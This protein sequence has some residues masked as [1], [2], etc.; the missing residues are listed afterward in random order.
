MWTYRSTTKVEFALNVPFKTNCMIV[1]K[2]RN[3][4]T[5]WA[6]PA[7]LS[8]LVSPP[9]AQCMMVY[10]ARLLTIGCAV[11]LTMHCGK[12][13]RTHYIVISE[14]FR[15]Q[16]LTLVDLQHACVGFTWRN[17]SIGPCC[18]SSHHINVIF[19]ACTTH[20]QQQRCRGGLAAGADVLAL[21][22]T[23]WLWLSAARHTAREAVHGAAI[24]RRVLFIT[25][26]HFPSLSSGWAMKVQ[27]ISRLRCAHLENKSPT[28]FSEREERRRLQFFFFPDG[29]RLRKISLK[30]EGHAGR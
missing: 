22:R 28:R 26:E 9:R 11:L 6:V 25:P 20:I 14:W 30:P 10:L 13:W 27:L 24:W 2:R 15:T 19:S 17:L 18:S 29:S 1:F 4:T 7:A 8:P 3:L 5:G 23:A 16:T 12:Q 21:S